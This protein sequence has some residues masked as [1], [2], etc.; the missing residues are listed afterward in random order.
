MAEHEA[1]F[2][3]APLR[4]FAAPT[5]EPVVD[6]GGIEYPDWAGWDITEDVKVSF[7]QDGEDGDWVAYVSQPAGDL[8]VKVKREQIVEMAQWMLW[9]CGEMVIATE[10]ISD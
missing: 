8:Y 2:V 7:G 4:M 6:A 9:A 3:Q 5:G 10:P 1:R